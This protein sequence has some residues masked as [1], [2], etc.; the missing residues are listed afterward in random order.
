ML[1]PL[2][3]ELMVLINFPMCW[4]LDLGP[5]YEQYW[6]VTSAPS[7]SPQMLPFLY[8]LQSCALF[9]LPSQFPHSTQTRSGILSSAT[10][11]YSRKHPSALNTALPCPWAP[12]PLQSCLSFTTCSSDPNTL[13]LVL[14]RETHSELEYTLISHFHQNHQNQ[15]VIVRYDQSIALS[16]K[17]DD[18]SMGIFK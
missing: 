12:R 16:Y 4:E 2:E 8:Y 3:L 14:G 15:H 10:S 13:H 5:L 9:A 11:A 18:I 6:L 7:S 17:S 1:H